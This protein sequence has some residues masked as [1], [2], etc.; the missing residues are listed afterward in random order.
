MGASGRFASREVHPF[1]GVPVRHPVDNNNGRFRR[2][3]PGLGIEVQ[4]YHKLMGVDRK[5][6]QSPIHAFVGAAQLVILLS[7]FN[8]PALMI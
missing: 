1:G 4:P 2:V 5:N 7:N 6:A 3:G 8:G